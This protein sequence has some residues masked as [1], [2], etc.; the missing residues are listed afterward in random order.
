MSAVF[1]G[2]NKQNLFLEVFFIIV[3]TGIWIISVM[4][5]PVGERHLCSGFWSIWSLNISARIC[6]QIHKKKIIGITRGGK[7]PYFLPVWKLWVQWVSHDTLD[8]IT[9][10]Y[11]KRWTS[12]TRLL[13]WE[14][15]LMM[16]MDWWV[17]LEY[18]RIVRLIF[19]S[20]IE[21]WTCCYFIIFFNI[22]Q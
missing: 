13:Y 14:D 8:V 1:V 10:H 3:C 9:A 4:W 22:W 11:K 17:S 12:R 6:S 15:C 16:S 20:D 21:I 18:L 19:L 7:S 5:S 2:F